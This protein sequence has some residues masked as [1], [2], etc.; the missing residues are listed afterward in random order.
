ML[1]LEAGPLRYVVPLNFMPPPYKALNRC[2]LP[3]LERAETGI[4]QLSSHAEP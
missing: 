1:Q 4:H 3:R 2:K